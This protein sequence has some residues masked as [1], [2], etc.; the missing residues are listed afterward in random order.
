MIAPELEGER[1]ATTHTHL[2]EV[3]ERVEELG[4]E[5]AAAVEQA[6][7][8]SLHCHQHQSDR[9]SGAP[10]VE[11]PAEVARNVVRWCRPLA[12][13]LV[14]AALLHDS[15][16][17]QHEILCALDGRSPADRHGAF[18]TIEA[19]FGTRVRNLV[20]HLTNP[21]HAGPRTAAEKRAEYLA[22]I[23]ELAEEGS[24]AYTV[25]LADLWTNALRL[26]GIA[27]ADKRSRL[28]LKYRPVLEDA[29][30]RLLEGP[31]PRLVGTAA[32]MRTELL[33]AIARMDA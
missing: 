11:H 10:Y 26:D 3:R 22:H 33:H 20:A 12:T 25:K 23:Q 17:D 2:A 8:V 4:A 29:A 7:A 30:T 5:Q 24:D 18:D 9:P 16:E 15:V 28:G 6:I 21:E 27:D 31:P 13:E 14:I 32:S 1:Y 19:R